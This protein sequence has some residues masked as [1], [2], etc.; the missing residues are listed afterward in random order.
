[1]SAVSTTLQL[2][3]EAVSLGSKPNPPRECVSLSE[4]P[5]PH[6]LLLLLLRFGNADMSSAAHVRVGG[7]GR[8]KSAL[9]LY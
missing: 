6:T 9:E 7:E 5:P 3:P 1:M 2:P 4:D 8:G